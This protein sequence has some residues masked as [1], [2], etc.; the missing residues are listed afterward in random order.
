MG[1]MLELRSPIPV[2]TPLGRG[3][4]LFME[5][6]SAEQ[7]WTVVLNDSRAFVTFRQSEIHA[8]RSYTY[9]RSMTDS[10]MAG[11]LRARPVRPTLTRMTKPRVR[12]RQR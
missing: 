4:A 5:S 1:E 9:G 3:W 7:Y 6:D 8:C 11:A 12:S 10:E 2:E